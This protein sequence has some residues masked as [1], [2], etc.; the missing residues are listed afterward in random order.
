MQT[1][2]QIVTVCAVI[3]VLDTLYL[4]YHKMRGTEVACWF[5]P[6]EWCVKVQHSPYGKTFGIP[7]SVAGLGMYLAMLVLVSLI[8]GGTAP[9]WALQALI[10]FGF[11]FS[12]YFVYVQAFI[13]RAFCTWCVV[14]AL[15]FVVLF[16][17]VFGFI[18]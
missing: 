7:N 1:T 12:L 13:L 2:L 15:N 14:S 4:I 6:K 8:A 5:F 9:F 16:G 10:A 11:A 17:A 18:G 3:G